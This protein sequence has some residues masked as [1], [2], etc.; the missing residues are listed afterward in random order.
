MHLEI[1]VVSQREISRQPEDCARPN[2]PGLDLLQWDLC[3][4]YFPWQPT[5]QPY[6]PPFLT[7]LDVLCAPTMPLFHLH[8]NL[9]LSTPRFDF[10]LVS[11]YPTTKPFLPAAPVDVCGSPAAHN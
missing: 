2:L 9:D 5:D 7:C 11:S 10:C 3:D 4:W 8:L 1:M 6:L